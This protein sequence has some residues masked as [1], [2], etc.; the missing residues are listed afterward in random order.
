MK[1]KNQVKIIDLKSMS[2][3]EEQRRKLRH[4]FLEMFNEKEILE[5][6]C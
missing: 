6:L 4:F 1:K 5:V 2:I 3:T